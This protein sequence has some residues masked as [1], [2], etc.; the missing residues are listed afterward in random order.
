MKIY[1]SRSWVDLVDIV[2]REL[3]ILGFSKFDTF[4]ENERMNKQKDKTN[5]QKKTKTSEQTNEGI[6][7]NKQERQ[8]NQVNKTKQN[9]KIRN[10]SL[11]FLFSRLIFAPIFLGRRLGTTRPSSLKSTTSKMADSA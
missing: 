3:E 10:V 8:V 5:K 4:K 7:E 9:R 6:K 1:G 11:P 2:A